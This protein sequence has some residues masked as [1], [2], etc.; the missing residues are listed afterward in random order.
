MQHT[1]KPRKISLWI[2]CIN[3]LWGQTPA[4]GKLRCSKAGTNQ[5]QLRAEHVEN[6][7]H[8]ARLCKVHYLRTADAEDLG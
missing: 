5:G 6:R 1:Q 7:A 2:L 8:D 3:Q 4:F